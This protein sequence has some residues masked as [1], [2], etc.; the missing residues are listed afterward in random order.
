MSRST[1]QLV[2]EINI[3][4]EKQ[5]A[6]QPKKKISATAL[7]TEFNRLAK[8]ADVQ[9]ELKEAFV[10]TAVSLWTR[11]FS[12]PEVL[13]LVRS[14]EERFGVTS[15]F[16]GISKLQMLLSKSGDAEN[17]AWTFALIED[18]YTHG[19][20]AKEGLGS[21]EINGTAP[22]RGGKGIVDEALFKKEFLTW[23][24]EE[25]LG[26]QP[27]PLPVKEKMR[28]ACA[29]HAIIR[30]MCG[31]P[32]AIGVEVADPDLTWQAGW[33]QSAVQGMEFILDSVYGRTHDVDMYKGMRGRKSAAEVVEGGSLKL[34]MDE[35]DE[36]LEKEAEEKKKED[37]ETL[38]ASESAASVDAGA[39]EVVA[40]A[41]S[42]EDIIKTLQKAGVEETIVKTLG[43][44]PEDDMQLLIK[45]KSRA[46]ALVRTY[47]TLIPEDTTE[48][49]LMKA[50]SDTP[51]GKLRGGLK[52]S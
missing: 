7:A 2:C 36:H 16:E 44:L 23:I 12:L 15:Q 49:K 50:I 30:K 4:K 28:A 31:C 11:A 19:M 37:K 52:D 51:A 17:I 41:N 3:F 26:S 14:C 33:P 29:Y 22:G 6:L 46:K 43:D 21:R 1:F 24:R 32:G 40:E 8:K 35:V 10:D 5:E 48:R 47:I 45:I 20:I 27:W 18:S 42:R 13:S 34:A 9:E 38:Q 39:V 25:W